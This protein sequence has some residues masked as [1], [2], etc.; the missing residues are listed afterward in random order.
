[1]AIYNIAGRKVYV[2]DGSEDKFMK[3]YPDA[4]MENQGE[5]TGFNT[6]KPTYEQPASSRSYGQADQA[7][8][9][10][11]QPR[12]YDEQEKQDRSLSLGDITGK[13]NA[14]ANRFMG[15][16]IELLGQG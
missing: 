16:N 9:M 2:P 10:Y 14:G 8:Q 4:V 12:G 3:A 6:P 11:Y 1:M 13:I 5:S 7:S 15:S